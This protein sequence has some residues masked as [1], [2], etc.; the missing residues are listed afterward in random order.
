MV[1]HTMFVCYNIVA[2]TA[3][4]RATVPARDF[5]DWRMG[6]KH[7]SPQVVHGVPQFAPFFKLGFNLDA[8]QAT[9]GIA[10]KMLVY[11]VSN[12]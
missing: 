4:E 5:P 6:Y 11:F 3:S 1:E 9:P 2:R 8:I 7:L 10:K 12:G